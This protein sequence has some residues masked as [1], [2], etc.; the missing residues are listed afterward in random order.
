MSRWKRWQRDFHKKVKELE[1][2]PFTDEDDEKQFFEIELG[3]RLREHICPE[4]PYTEIWPLLSGYRFAGINARDDLFAMCMKAGQRI[5]FLLTAAAWEKEAARYMESTLAPYRL[6]ALDLETKTVTRTRNGFW[7]ERINIYDKL[8]Q[9]SAPHIKRS[10]SYAQADTEYT[11]VVNDIPRRVT[12][13]EAFTHKTSAPPL[14]IDHRREPLDIS[15]DDLL[16]AATEM[17]AYHPSGKWVDRMNDLQKRLA[18]NVGGQL[19]RSARSLRLDGIYNLIGIGSSGKSTLL[20]VL[21]YYLT[22][23][24]QLRV[25]MITTTLVES[26]NM[27]ETFVQMGVKAAPV[28]GHD[29]ASHRLKFGQAH[30]TDLLPEDIFRTDASAR[31]SLEWMSAPCAIAGVT[32]F[33]PLGQEPCTSL[34]HSE[35]LYACPLFPSCPHHQASQ[36]LAEAQVWI[37]TPASFLYTKAPEQVTRD[38]IRTLELMY[39]ECDAV[40]FD[41]SDLLQTRLDAE[42]APMND[43]RGASDEAILSLIDST[44]SDAFLRNYART[45]LNPSN[46]DQKKLVEEARHFADLVLELQGQHTEVAALLKERPLSMISLFRLLASQL[47]TNE[48]GQKDEDSAERLFEELWDFATN[49]G[50]QLAEI[51]NDVSYRKA[52]TLT[53]PLYQ[54]LSS[55][56]RRAPVDLAGHPQRQMLLLKLEFAICLASMDRRFHFLEQERIHAGFG[57]GGRLLDQTPPPEYQDIVPRN[58]FGTQLGYQLAGRKGGPL[59]QYLQ[60]RGIGRWI[61]L[62]YPKLFLPTDGIRGPH[63][64]FA[65]ATGYAPGSPQF[66]IHVPVNAVLSPPAEELQAIHESTFKFLFVLDSTGKPIR[67]SGTYGEDGQDPYRNLERLVR[68]LAEPGID[69]KSILEHDFDFCQK[70]GRLPALIVNSYA[71]VDHVQKILQMIPFWH[72]RT[73]AMKPDAE[74]DQAKAWQLETTDSAIRRGEIERLREKGQKL[75]IFPLLAFQRSYN[76]LDDQGKALLGSAYF[77]VRPFPHPDDASLPVI[78]ANAYAINEM[79]P[80]WMLPVSYGNS[81]TKMMGTLRQHAYHQWMRRMPSAQI[82]PG[83]R[84]LATTPDL[85]KEYLWDQFIIVWQACLRFFR[86]GRSASIYFV[87]GAFHPM[88]NTPSTLRGWIHILDE[89]LS[90]TSTK[91]PFDKQLIEALYGPAYRALKTLEKEL[92]R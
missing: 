73:I 68:Y 30:K 40:A 72:D 57:Q 47:C 91:K 54:W 44:L 20:W 67:V 71:Q 32:G 7:P 33:I 12:I 55:A 78:G 87:D 11:F 74:S 75:P 50:G 66:H 15:F 1:E 6:Y 26:V 56:E 90:P 60:S 88:D 3:L 70:Q 51:A 83:L 64:I 63:A 65:S 42:F 13:P 38:D 35:Q 76:I 21:T 43:L 46:K 92:P 8:L 9:E 23:K 62:H 10:P 77:L 79:L 48:H 37:A 14:S 53:G 39:R 34:K 2:S 82:V 17:E 61:L 5:R 31:P 59:L 58:P 29:R 28:S 49:Q 85:Y 24:L 25:G 84:G 18:Q 45:A 80:D 4:A 19:D 52:G 36:D 22:T 41:E 16:Q 89:Y 69:G 27:A 86:G 81:A